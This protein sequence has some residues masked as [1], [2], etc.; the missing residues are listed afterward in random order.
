MLNEDELKYLGI[1]RFHEAGYRGQGVKIASR[2]DV[3]EGKFDDIHAIKFE[4]DN[5]RFSVH[6][7]NVMDY[8]RQVC[9]DAYKI[10]AE[11]H[12]SISKGILTS[13]GADYLLKEQPDILTTSEWGNW[14]L[15]E[16]VNAVY[17]TLKSRGTYLCCSAGNEDTGG[18]IK[19]SKSDLW[20]A[21]GACRYNKGNPKKASYSS[22][23][24]ELDYMSFDHLKATHDNRYH[25]GTSFASPLFAGMLALVQC[26]FIEN[27]GRKL[28]YD[29]LEFFIQDNCIDLGNEGRDTHYGY[30]LFILPDPDT[31]DCVR[32]S[33]E[34]SMKGVIKLKVGSKI[35][36]IGKDTR[37]M[38]VE[39]FIMNDRTYVPIRFV[40][41]ALG[42]EV[43]W[44]GETREVTI[45]K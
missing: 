31:I 36:Q 44:N 8:I 2:E 27:I 20:K 32:Y 17:E 22:I 39:P 45:I 37:V 24:E 5:G 41:E 25:N 14:D 28:T 11:L 16:P 43:K 38:D 21:I 26:F 33:G 13:A 6:G 3:Q 4:D 34:V 30:G 29:E 7:T 9:P 23:G 42:C 15:K 35:I 19:L 12:G 40:A 1:T 18:C 10:T